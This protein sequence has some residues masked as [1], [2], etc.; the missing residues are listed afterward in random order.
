MRLMCDEMLLRLG[1]W[2]RAAGYDTA[3]VEGGADDAALIGRCAAEGRV[4]LTRDR[5]LAA[6]AEACIPVLRLAEDTIDG[7]ARALAGGLGIDWRHAPFTRCVIDNAVLAP[8]P[9]EA[10]AEVPPRSREAGGPL[11]RCPSCRRLYWPGGH[12]RRMRERLASWAR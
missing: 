1:R 2:L 8:A 12:V 3:I 7:Q 4:L 6:C 9:P 10:M 11:L 5:R